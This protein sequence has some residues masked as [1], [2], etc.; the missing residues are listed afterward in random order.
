MDKI[1]HYIGTQ[2][3]KLEKEPKFGATW[4]SRKPKTDQ[5][6]TAAGWIWYLEVEVLNPVWPLVCAP[7]TQ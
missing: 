6:A 4:T 2:E 3:E 5:K 1:D 7:V